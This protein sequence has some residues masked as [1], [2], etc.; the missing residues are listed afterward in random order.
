MAEQIIITPNDIRVFYP[1]LSTNIA[2]D[3]ITPLILLAQQNDLEPFLGW[4]LYN[5]FIEDYN[6]A[7]FATAKYQELYDGGI[8]TYRSN[9]RYHRGIKHL[10]CIYAFIRLMESSD[11]TLTDSGLV[12]KDTEE[13]EPKTDSQIRMMM[14]KV[15]DDSIRLERDNQDFI[16]TKITDYPLYTKV[17]STRDEKTSYNFYKV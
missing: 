7:T 14:R 8:Y 1:Q 5:A 9:D 12:Y 13:S 6:G 15:K 2:D 10:L 11:I 4:Y 16:R 17:Y 3:S